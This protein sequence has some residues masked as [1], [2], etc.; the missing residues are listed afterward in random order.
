VSESS[1]TFL[2][3]TFR[4]LAGSTHPAYSLNCFELEE[5]DFRAAYFRPSAGQVFV[6]VGASYGA[7]SLSAAAHGAEVHAF[8]PETSVFVDLKRNAEANGFEISL[9]NSGL[10][11][12]DDVVDMSSYAPHWPPGT[13]SAPFRMLTLDSFRLPRLDWLKVDVEG[14]EERVLRGARETIARCR[15]RVIVECHT[16]LDPA[17]TEKCVALLGGYS[18]ETVDRPPCVMIVGTPPA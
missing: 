1:C 6:D 3:K 17:L 10:W 8:E 5:A 2:G 11:D 9:H 16:F 14:A 15:P 18:I 13:I 7:Y 4:M 12:G